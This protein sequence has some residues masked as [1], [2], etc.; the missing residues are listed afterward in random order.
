RVEKRIPGCGLAGGRGG[1]EIEALRQRGDLGPLNILR[2]ECA[3]FYLQR[4]NNSRLVRQ[5]V[6]DHVVE[7]TEKC[8][9]EYADLIG[10]S[11]HEAVGIVLL[12]H[13][14]ETVQHA[15]NFADIVCE[16]TR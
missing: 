15:S 4:L 1:S 6:F 9:I 12:Y 8:T 16:A 5:I 14:Q 10:R 3:E 13:L 7:T 11:N 2:L